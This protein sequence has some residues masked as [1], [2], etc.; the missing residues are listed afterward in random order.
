MLAAMS[1]RVSKEG[2]ALEM[3]M[4]DFVKALKQE[5][6]SVTWVFTKAEFESRVDAAVEKILMG[7]K[8]ESI[9]VV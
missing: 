8:E 4:E 5:I 2:I 1:R 7:I 6:D 9:K 3:D